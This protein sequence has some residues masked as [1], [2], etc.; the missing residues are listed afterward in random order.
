MLN[1]TLDMHPRCFCS[2]ILCSDAEKYRKDVR[3]GIF[4]VD[5]R[6]P[7]TELYRG[8]ISD[9]ILSAGVKSP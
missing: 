1:C 3:S 5:L 2:L 7:G 6:Y 9:S 8:V 4:A